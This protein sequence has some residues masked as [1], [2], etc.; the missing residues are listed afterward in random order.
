MILANSSIIFVLWQQ[1]AIVVSRRQGDM[2]GISAITAGVMFHLWYKVSPLFADKRPG[3]SHACAREAST[4]ESMASPARE[5]CDDTLYRFQA[6]C[7]ER[8]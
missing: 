1:D 8:M 4:Q 7:L 5:H 2:P 6:L 3:A